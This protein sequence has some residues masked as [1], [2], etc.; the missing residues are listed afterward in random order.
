V[1]ALTFLQ[2]QAP[3]FAGTA[4][5]V[6]VQLA[7]ASDLKQ[8]KPGQT[9]VFKGA[10]V[11]ALHVIATGKAQILGKTSSGS[12][13]A[14][15]ELGPGDVFGEASIVEATV[16]GANVK[17]GETGTMVLLIPE[18]AFRRAL[19]EEVA[20]A[21]RVRALIASRRPSSR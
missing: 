2:T 9:I 13:V 6:L 11:D 1:D 15:A 21:E 16:S 12:A 14:L 7:A 5:G 8:F 3:L 18:D 17:A 10:T 20:F 19:S 4:E